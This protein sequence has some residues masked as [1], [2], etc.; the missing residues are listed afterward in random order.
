MRTRRD[1]HPAS[2]LA[3]ALVLVWGAGIALAAASDP[4]AADRDR[5]HSTSPAA[6]PAAQGAQATSGFVGDET[7]ATCHESEKK[8]LNA[9]LHGKVQNTRTPAARTDQSCETCHGPGAEARGFRQ[10]GRHPPVRRAE[11][12]AR[13]TRPA[14]RATTSRRTRSGRA[15]CTKPATFPARPVTAFTARSPSTPS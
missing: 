12:R 10:E 4:P 2:L 5:S 8:T 1:G 13:Q 7:C 14:C 3:T 6:A 15:A 9:T 11:P